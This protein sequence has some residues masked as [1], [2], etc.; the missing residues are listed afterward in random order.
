MKT[1][2][3]FTFVEVLAVISVL[4]IISILTITIINNNINDSKK[5]IYNKQI[6]ILK[7][8]ANNYTSD[9]IK[10]IESNK[11]NYIKITIKILKDKGYLS[12]KFINPITNKEFDNNLVIV[13]KKINKNYEYIFQ[14]DENYDENEYLCLDERYP[15]LSY[16]LPPGYHLGNNKQLCAT[17]SDNYSGIE[18]LETEL[19]KNN[20]LYKNEKTN[21]SIYC[22]NLVENINYTLYGKAISRNGNEQ[23]KTK[24][25]ERGFYYENYKLINNINI[26]G[27]IPSGKLTNKDVILKIS[28]NYIDKLASNITYQWQK[29]I[30]NTWVDIE[31]SNKN[32]YTETNTKLNI[33]YRL[34]LSETYN[35][36]TITIY[37]NEYIIYIDKI[38]PS[39]VV[40]NLNGYINNT[41]TNKNIYQT[42]TSYDNESGINRYEYSSDNKIWNTISNVDTFS[43]GITI[44]YIRSV[45][46]AGNI[47]ETSDKY[48]MKID[49]IKPTCS[50]S[51]GSSLWTN[52]TVNIKGTC[53]DNGGSNCKSNSY[54]SYSSD[55]NTSSANPGNITDNAGNISTCPNTTVKVDKTPPSNVITNLNG[56]QSGTWTK[57]NVR[58]I[59]SSTDYGSGIKKYL[60]GH[61]PSGIGTDIPKD[62]TITW[63]GNWIFYVKAIDNAGNVSINPSTYRIQIDKTPPSVPTYTSSVATTSSKTSNLSNAFNNRQLYCEAKGKSIKF[64]FFKY[65]TSD[66]VGG[67]G[68]PSKPIQRK[69]WYSPSASKGCGARSESETSFV[70]RS[71]GYIEL[72]QCNSGG[73][74]HSIAKA[75]D[76]VG[77]CS[78]TTPVNNVYWNV[79]TIS[80]LLRGISC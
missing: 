70:S 67:S 9:N 6:K 62:W 79:S 26:I 22:Y 10:E 74:G 35:N 53:I 28:D 71:N 2:K 15:E 14:L 36:E 23:V 5:T 44:R 59:Q 13:I 33:K 76:N 77:N 12:K 38:K 46:N 73:A 57:N 63:D 19:Y 1:K 61:S 8:S 21:R 7:Q 43:N 72:L 17:A 55:I 58:Q 37:S 30:N 34:K 80:S 24:E 32:T 47:S 65:T 66:N 52:K 25:D 69:Y 18:M 4:S 64:A 40:V 68:L 60:Y 51:G 16:S 49:N 39:K 11:C 3:G 48:I 50:T 41:W 27:S 31:N 75:C 56:Y 78:S 54:K 29:F 45:D 42:F 20:L